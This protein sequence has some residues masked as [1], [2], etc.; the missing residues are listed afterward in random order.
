M[1]ATKT[2]AAFT[3]ASGSSTTSGTTNAISTAGLYAAAIYASIVQVGNGHHGCNVHCQPK[4]RWVDLL[5]RP[6]LHRGDCRGNLHAGTDPAR[7]DLRE[8]VTITYVA[9]PVGTSTTA[10]FQLGEVTGVLA[11]ALYGRW[12]TKP[13]P[14]TQIDSTPR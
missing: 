4:S 12:Q 3:W 10:T 2:S 6:D 5:R 8:R 14:G 11:M 7:P 9:Q 13:P 1:S